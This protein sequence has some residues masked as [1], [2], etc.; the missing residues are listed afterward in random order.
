MPKYQDFCTDLQEI[1]N[2]YDRGK[3]TKDDVDAFEK[4][5]ADMG[6]QLTSREQGGQLSGL[7]GLG[8]SIQAELHKIKLEK[9]WVTNNRNPHSSNGESQDGPLFSKDAKHNHTTLAQPAS[10]RK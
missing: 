9:G 1:L 6:F 7:Q 3:L 8:S 10:S 5:Y 4:K 2:S